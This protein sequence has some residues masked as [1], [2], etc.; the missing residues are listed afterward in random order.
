[1]NSKQ[2]LAHFHRLAEAP[3][4]IP[5]LR[6][7]ILD[8]AV[9]GKLVPQDPKDEPADEL[10]KRIQA[11]KERLVKDGKM[12]KGDELPPM[13]AQELSFELPVGWCATRLEEIAACLNYMREP[14]N[15]TEREQRIAGKTQAELYPYYGATQ[16]Q[17]WKMTLSSMKN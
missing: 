10:L 11:E 14:I 2:L 16:Q 13:D 6:R 1:M 5:R 15:G 9:R 8:L 12:K 3:D 17:G 4:A 7:F